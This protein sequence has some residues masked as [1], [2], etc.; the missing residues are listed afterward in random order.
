MVEG[1]T[2]EEGRAM[3]LRGPPPLP[4]GSRRR[5]RER[6]ARHRGEKGRE[7]P[8]GDCRGGR[9][10]SWSSRCGS[11]APAPPARPARDAP[12]DAP[13]EPPPPERERKRTP[14]RIRPCF[15]SAPS[16]SQ[17]HSH[18][19]VPRQGG[20][21]GAAVDLTVAA[22]E[23][24][25]ARVE[26]GG[27]HALLK[28]VDHELLGVWLRR[29]VCVH[30]VVDSP[31]AESSREVV[32]LDPSRRQRPRERRREARERDDRQRDRE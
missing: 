7:R 15:A 2:M 8:T 11:A 27:R 22:M 16:P 10:H 20:R 18:A 25:G 17:F 24:G 31:A 4:P 29:G 1:N 21:R 14:P 19:M 12:R 3:A 13:R 23:G 5:G 30:E 28:G 26:G 32:P 6:S 9:R